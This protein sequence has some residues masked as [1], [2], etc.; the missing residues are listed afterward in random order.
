MKAG[1]KNPY[2]N[3]QRFEN[4]PQLEKAEM[5]KKSAGAYGEP[6]GIDYDKLL[7]NIIKIC[8]NIKEYCNEVFA[9]FSSEK[10]TTNDSIHNHEIKLVHEEGG[11][12]PKSVQFS[13]GAISVASSNVGMD[14]G[15]GELNNKYIKAGKE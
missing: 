10:N 7:T 11:I 8:K 1:E 3:F 5:T 15:L 4:N 9:R 2:E 13:E 6:T 14:G 12:L